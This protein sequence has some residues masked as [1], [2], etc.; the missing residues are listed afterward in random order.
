M[1]HAT[2]VA[3]INRGFHNMEANSRDMVAATGGTPVE[4]YVSDERYRAECATVFR[5]YPLVIAHS[6]QL[7]KPGD[8]LSH[9]ETGVPILLMRTA[10]GDVGA[11][12]NVCRH[13][14]SRLVHARGGNI[15]RALV[16]P[17]HA[18]TYDL[19]GRLVG[20]PQ[21]DGFEGFDQAANGLIPLPVEE[22]YGF[23]WVVPTPG[24]DIDVTGYLG[25]FAKD[26]AAYE[27]NDHSLFEPMLWQQEMNWKGVV[28][29][30]L[31]SYHFQF[32][33]PKSVGP[34]FLQN[35]IVLD[36]AG[37]HV[38][39]V[40]MKKTLQQLKDV[41]APE[42]NIR[43]H[44]ILL[45]LIFPN[46]VVNWAIDHLEVFQTFPTGPN[47]AKMWMSF[48]GSEAPATEA[49]RKH[50]HNTKDLTARALVEDFEVGEGIHRNFQ[51]GAFPRTTFGRYEQ[52]L[53]AFHRGV[54]TAAA[55]A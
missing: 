21:A 27:A 42:W 4:E 52:A 45:Y 1:E 35:N 10:S 43:P 37:P 19:E 47:N 25:D 46:T 24:A 2:Q 36:R 17:Y 29:T 26:F 8:Y 32:L 44:A 30:F 41:A 39:I 31:E 54:E 20:I 51:A 16:C 34:L 22:K 3:L 50:W 38:R 28:D 7:A 33:H 9:D 55:A 40:T 6:S 13:R 11:F 5:K 49:A 14:C 18:W 12:M 15:G 23:I 48:Y 53:E